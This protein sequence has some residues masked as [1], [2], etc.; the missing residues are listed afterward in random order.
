MMRSKARLDD[1]LSVPGSGRGIGPPFEPAE[2]P[3][4]GANRVPQVD[5][6]FTRPEDELVSAPS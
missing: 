6:R 5:N 1:S 4:A 2:C 3:D